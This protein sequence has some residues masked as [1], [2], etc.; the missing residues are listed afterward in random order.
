MTERVHHLVN[1]RVHSD[2]SRFPL[3]P[4]RLERQFC[5]CHSRLLFFLLSYFWLL[6][7]CALC[8]NKH[9]EWIA[10]GATC[11]KYISRLF[12]GTRRKKTILHIHE[13]RLDCLILECRLDKAI[14]F[15]LRFLSG[16]SCSSFGTRSERL[17]NKLCKLIQLELAVLK[18]NLAL[19]CFKSFAWR[20]KQFSEATL[21][22]R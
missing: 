21:V 19:G 9:M 17:T 18:A 20:I 16:F 11:A 13:S 14:F 8:A 7:D 3:Y 4:P 10:S 22:I 6:N 5:C 12:E 15:S 1:L 2:S